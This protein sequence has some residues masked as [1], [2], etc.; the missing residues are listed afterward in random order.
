MLKRNIHIRIP[1]V[2]LV[3][4]NVGEIMSM[5]EMIGVPY[6]MTIEAVEVE[7]DTEE[8][9]H[10]FQSDDPRTDIL[11][12]TWLAA[13]SQSFV[14]GGAESIKI[15]D[16]SSEEKIIQ[17]FE[18]MDM[19]FSN[20]KLKS[21]TMDAGEALNLG[22]VRKDIPV[23]FPASSILGDIN[24]RIGTAELRTDGTALMTLSTDGAALIG[25]SDVLNLSIA[26][27]APAKPLNPFDLAA[28]EKR[29]A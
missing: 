28:G 18:T 9:P 12:E 29:D 11:A 22:V 1:E 14:D 7:S 10:T 2:T 26:T 15:F 17:S 4:T 27:L 6:T 21:T 23:V 8:V 5:L 20:T 13:N 25:R 3:Q 24:T 16:L 19:D